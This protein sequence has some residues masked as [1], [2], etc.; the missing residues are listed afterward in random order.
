MSFINQ[1]HVLIVCCVPLMVAS[2]IS[3]AAANPRNTFPGRRVGGGTRGECTSRIVAHLVPVSNVFGMSTSGDLALVQGPT[4][5]PV[6]LTTRFKP[7]AGGAAVS[8]TIPASSA[9][10]TVIRG[11]SITAPTVWESSFDCAGGGATQADPL[12]FVSTVS[13]PAVS[14]LVPEQETAD[15]ATQVALTSLSQHCGSTV[16]T[17]STLA[18]FGLA[19]LITPQWPENL[20][21]RCL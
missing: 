5:N 13:P 2:T 15:S 7:E 21:V 14:L 12:S 4:A 8:R 19:D 16:P 3:W 17:A 10:F 20:P 6:A 9:G 1:R 18:S 11:R